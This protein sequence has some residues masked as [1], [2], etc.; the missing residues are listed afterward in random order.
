ML[1]R[2][3]WRAELLCHLQ[4]GPGPGVAAVRPPLATALS[5]LTSAGC[6]TI[7]RPG[8]RPLARD[9]P[10][11]LGRL[12]FSRLAGSVHARLGGLRAQGSEG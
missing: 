10:P 4:P 7:P 12:G 5:P 6:Q 9:G 8:W 2:I 3:S 1:V 11:L